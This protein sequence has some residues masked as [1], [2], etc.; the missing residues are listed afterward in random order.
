VS[1]KLLTTRGLQLPDDYAALAVLLNQFWAEPTSADRLAQEDS[2]MYEVGS[3]WVDEHGC[4]QGYDRLREVVVGSSGEITGYVNI[5]RAPWTEPGALNMTLIVDKAWRKQ[6]AGE[7]LLQ[8]AMRW[9]AQKQGSAVFSELWDDDNEALS[10][11]QSR[12]FSIDRHTFQ[13]VL[14]LEADMAAQSSNDPL[15]GAESDWTV[16]DQLNHEGIRFITLADEPGEESEAKLHVLYKE[17]LEDIPGFTGN[18]P[19]FEEWRK[20]Y[21]MPEGFAPELV[22]IAVDQERYIGI[23]NLLYHNETNGIYHEYT[24]VSKSYRGRKIATALKLF[25]IRL[26]K[27]RKA[28]Y[29]RTDNDSLNEPMLAINRKLG[30]V[31]QR[32]RYRMLASI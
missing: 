14:H 31:Q 23:S 6:G 25:S 3:T 2:M 24:G 30:Y 16:F 18:V 13:S 4:L 5:W 19:D 9:A 8:A 11:A 28:S 27:Q 12:G 1:N 20:W 7:M 21:L 10:F 15:A 22:V 29:L 17:T 26:A 32:G